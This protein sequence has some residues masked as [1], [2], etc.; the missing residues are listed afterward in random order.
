MEAMADT[1][2]DTMLATVEV[3]TTGNDISLINVPFSEK[4]E[5]I[6]I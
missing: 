3:I 2:V 5:S 1:V 4:Y 6:L